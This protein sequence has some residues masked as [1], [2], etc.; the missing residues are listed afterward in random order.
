MMRIL[1]TWM[2]VGLC[3]C[4]LRTQGG[5]GPAGDSGE[6]VASIPVDVSAFAHEIDQLVVDE[7]K[8]IGQAP[9]PVLKAQKH[10]DIVVDQ[11]DAFFRLHLKR[12][13]SRQ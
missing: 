11:L 8:R 5:E 12:Q 1:M 2:A 10:F 9:R 6:K 13:G 3:V 4:V 7:L